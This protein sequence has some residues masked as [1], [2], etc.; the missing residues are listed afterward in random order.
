MANKD[1]F[2]LISVSHSHRFTVTPLVGE[3]GVR[4][5]LIIRELCFY[6]LG[7]SHLYSLTNA[8]PAAFSR[9]L[10]RTYIPSPEC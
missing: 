2:R 8:W 7:R 4:E 5:Y 6:R 3:P 1:S 9:R 10:R